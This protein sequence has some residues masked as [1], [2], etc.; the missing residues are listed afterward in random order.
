MQI[1][2]TW[3]RLQRAHHRMVGCHN[4]LGTEFSGWACTH[5]RGDREHGAFG[6]RKYC[7]IFVL[8][9][10]KVIPA[11]TRAFLDYV[12]ERVGNVKRAQSAAKQVPGTSGTMGTTD[13]TDAIH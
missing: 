6:A 5:K 2:I 13:A 12:D 4:A 10:R 9:T 8:P 7:S 3:L 11:R 1:G